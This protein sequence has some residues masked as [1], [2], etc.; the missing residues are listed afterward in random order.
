MRIAFYTDTYL[1]NRDGVVTA[2]V[3][4]R[5]QLE[6]DGHEV[7]IFASGSRK[8]KKENTDPHV[9]FH[10]AV[11]FKPYPQYKIALFPFLSTSKAKQ[12]GID[13]VHSHGMAAMGLAAERTA[14]AL[15]VPYL[16]T[17]HTLI[18]R[19]THYIA[20]GLKPI[21]KVTE[22]IAWAYL[23]WYYNR[24][25]VAI[26]SSNTIRELMEEH[27]I[28]NVRVVPNGIDIERFNPKVDEGP[29]RDWWGL[30]GNK[31]VL[32]IGRLVLEKNLDVVIN[33]ALL[34]LEKEPD[35]RFLVVG[36]GP[37]AA[38]YRRLAEKKGVLDRFIFTGFVEDRWVPNYYACAD[39]VV[40]P[41]KF[42]TQGLVTLE[43]MACGKPVAGA[44]YLA[45]KEI[46]RDGVN[47]F[48]F[49]P[50]D[51]EECAEKIV[52]ALHSKKKLRANARK[53]AEGYSIK[54]C[55]ERLLSLYEELM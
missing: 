32:Y 39:A 49:N 17:L 27:G 18:P 54:R 26:A 23:K 36:T 30:R 29:V 43:A 47:G 52:E 50:D 13:I 14:R 6:A 44:D 22:R 41:S 35:A 33:S 16:G 31:V 51:P 12:L 10:L 24:C 25:D 42:E 5:K 9:F 46:I 19:A 11:P 55:T 48:L 7:F 21:N 38:Y 20:G 34:V 28:R 8:A 53:T 2:I 37:A 15:K 45:T 40:M 4:F 3:N 1:P